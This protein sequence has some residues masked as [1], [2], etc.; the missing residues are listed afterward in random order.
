MGCTTQSGL[1]AGAVVGVLLAILG[2]VL[3]PVGNIIIENEIKKEAVI[4]NGTIAYDNWVKTSSPVYRQFWLFHVLN[5]LDVITYGVK[6]ELTQKGPYTYRI[7]NLSKEN[8]TMGENHTVS[9]LQPNSAEFQRDMSVGSE[10][11]TVIALNLAVASAPSLFPI[12]TILNSLI[13]KSNSSLFQKRTVREMLWGYTDPLLALINLPALGTKTGVLYPY[14]GTADGLYTIFTGKDDISKTAIIKYYKGAENLSFWKG[15][16]NMINGTDGVS[17]PPFVDKKKKLYIFNSDICRSIY[18]E[19]EGEH[20]LKGIPVYRFVIPEHAF[21]SPLVNPD[22]LCFCTELSVSRNCTEGGIQDISACQNGKPVYISLPHFLYASENIKGL[23]TGLKPS[24]EEHRIFLDVDPITGFTLRA[25]KR[26][27][28]NLMFKPTDKIE[29]FSKLKDTLV[30]PVVWLNETAVVDDDT[31]KMFKATVTTP[32][33]ILMIVQVVL[34]CLGI[35]GFL[36]CSIALCIYSS[37][38]SK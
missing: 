3:I 30:F 37:R 34:L 31:A 20:N 21:A 5:P 27:Q 4:E 16:C 2:G 33:N 25:A 8:I 26:I 9:F 24:E 13:K 23:V 28:I 18:A 17:F 29:V 6:P 7:R 36:A 1:I 14:N 10:D 19:F 22:N 12:W 38:K 35:V 32:M 11:D 15:N